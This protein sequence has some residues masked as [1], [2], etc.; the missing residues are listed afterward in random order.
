[1][2]IR[3]G[4]LIAVVAFAAPVAAQHDH[5]TSSPA[6]GGDVARCAQ[7]QPVVAAMIDAAAQRLEAAR[8]SN[9]ASAM[10]AAV[11]DFDGLL[12]DLRTQLAPCNGIETAA[13]SHAGHAA[14]PAAPTSL[15]GAPAA[16]AP[17]DPHAGH[18]AGPEA[19]TSASPASPA[20]P[21]AP[22]A[23]TASRPAPATAARTQR[24]TPAAPASPD[25]HAGHQMPAAA[26]RT[27]VA[28]P[29]A[30][31]VTTA[32]DPH[33]GHSATSSADPHAGHTSTAAADAHAGHQMPTTAASG[34]TLW[35]TRVEALTCATAVDPKATPRTTYR[36]VMYFF[37]SERDRQDFLKSPAK[38][39]AAPAR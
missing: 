6:G 14:T 16:A 28:K 18:H 30:A 8:Q 3:L 7:A 10:R 39:V 5:S 33:A 4:L 35:S 2:T 38:Y 11:A 1:M 31:T 29:Q 17:A 15:V 36:G 25:P 21:A 22:A 26:P 9:S 20:A 13:D 27:N 34:P 24:A 12:R 19:S 32:V 37:C 23:P